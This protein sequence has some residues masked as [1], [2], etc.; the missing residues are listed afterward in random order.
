MAALCFFTKNTEGFIFS[1]EVVLLLRISEYLVNTQ[2]LKVS[3]D[4]LLIVAQ[5]DSGGHLL[6][7]EGE[8]RHVALAMD[9]GDLQ[10]LDAGI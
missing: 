1:V 3:A 6:A 8:H 5:G 10:V 4:V 7:F 9:E 2:T